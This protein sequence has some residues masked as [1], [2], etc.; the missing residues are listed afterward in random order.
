GTPP[1][2][3]PPDVPELKNDGHSDT[4]TMRQ[5]ME[6]HRANPACASCH[7]RMDPIGFGLESF[8]GIGMS[9]EK[10][11]EFAIDSS[12]K[13]VTGEAF[14]GAVDLSAILATKKRTEFLHCL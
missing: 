2:P 8:D 13:L 7:E 12:G 14:K 6:Q 4:G 9:R 11:G 5:Q 3:P 1:P 10:E